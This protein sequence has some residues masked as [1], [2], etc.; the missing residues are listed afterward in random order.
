[1]NADTRD[2]AYFQDVADAQY[3]PECNSEKHKVGEQIKR[4]QLKDDC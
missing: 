4:A 1:M 2:T 3:K